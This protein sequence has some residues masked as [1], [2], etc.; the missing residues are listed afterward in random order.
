[1]SAARCP[2]CSATL[3]GSVEWCSQCYADLRPPAPAP[4]QPPPAPVPAPAAPTPVSLEVPLTAIVAGPLDTPL[5]LATAAAMADPL[6]A[7]LGIVAGAEPAA[8]AVA[9][10]V[11][12][13]QL[14][15]APTPPPVVEGWPCIRCATVNP[16]ERMECGAC[17]YAFGSELSD[18]V[19][20]PG[21]RQ[22]RIV[23]TICA[24]VTVLAVLAAIIYATTPEPEKKDPP[25]PVTNEVRPLDPVD[26]PVEDPAP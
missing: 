21:T 20:V 2:K 3:L 1:M 25:A 6:T 12:A 26:E 16:M 9:A 5:A 23:I 7:P 4:A 10:A 17:G 11:G 13:D 8:A 14:Q 22:S 19:R 15:A 24:V 18:P